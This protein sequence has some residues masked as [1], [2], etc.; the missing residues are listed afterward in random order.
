MNT[1]NP[2]SKGWLLILLLAVVVGIVFITGKALHGSTTVGGGDYGIIFLLLI[3]I[4]LF[5]ILVFAFLV[6]RNLSRLWLDHRRQR[7]G[8]RLRTRMVALFVALSL[9]PTLIIAI[10]SV[11]FL[12]RGVDSWFSDRITFALDHSL[13]VARSYYRE[14]QKTV[15]HD[16]EDIAR[17][18]T[19]LR[20]LS[21][22]GSEAATAALEVERHARGLD[23]IA[24]IRADG[25]RIARAGELP[26]DPI[27]D[28]TSISEGSTHAILIT[29][30]T[31][32]R[33]R[34]FVKLNDELYLSTGHWIDHQILGQMETI[35][36]TYVEYHQLRAAHGLLKI[37]HTV[38]LILITLLLLL[39]AF[40]S[41][42]RIADGITDPITE[43]VLGTRQVSMGDLTVKLEVTGNDELSTLMAAFNAMTRKLDENRQELQSTNELLEERQRF[44]AAIVNN[45]SSGVISVNRQAQITL[46][47][48]VAANLL[49]MNVGEAIGT[50]YSQILP[51]AILHPIETLLNS[52]MHRFSSTSAPLSAS[53]TANSGD[54]YCQLSTQIQLQ[55]PVKPLTLLARITFLESRPSTANDHTSSGQSFIATFDD[56]TDVL[57]AQRTH[58]WSEVARR[59]AHEIKNPLTPIQLWAQRMRRKYLQPMPSDQQPDWR[60]LDEGTSS[61]IHQV[62]E[63]KILVN[64]FS[65]FARMPRPSFKNHDFHDTIRKV[66][67]LYDTDQKSFTIQTD[68]DPKL[69]EFPFDQGQIRQVL[70]NLMTNA[71]AACQEQHAESL[72]FIKTELS[73]N[74]N[75]VRLEFADNGPGIPP[76]DRDRIFEPYFTTR[77]K[78]TG[79][80]LAIVKKII[81]DHGG[82]IRMR[83]SLWKGALMEINI[84]LRRPSNFI[85]TEMP[86]GT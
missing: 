20:A 79:L 40:W 56:L 57:L 4:N 55:G 17:N 49:N 3:Y 15:R 59:I 23:E 60:I 36:A 62:D 58:A 68:F 50:P 80:G 9:L 74:G 45:I 71:I 29:N 14:N 32:D 35:E 19:V 26:F 31:G 63:L 27:P 77:K 30:D 86:E 24:I 22:Q 25:A 1:T 75:W 18:R 12:N 51:A 33:V 7:T 37:N 11:N 43:L 66:I 34:A 48:P 41:G 73:E 47:N 6:I 5:L 67:L 65:T 46:I 52:S 84:P 70:T 83:E 13:E 10:L 8:S 72:L 42:F 85:A 28:L 21:L 76:Q 39:T 64:E 82:T 69:P 38:T 53:D 44:M 81:E 16:A 61:I 2:K 54:D 78:G